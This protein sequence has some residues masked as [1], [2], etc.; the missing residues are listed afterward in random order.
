MNK[1]KLGVWMCKFIFIGMLI[2]F[3]I[4]VVLNL[5]PIK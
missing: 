2:V 5:K 4:H 3:A 1:E